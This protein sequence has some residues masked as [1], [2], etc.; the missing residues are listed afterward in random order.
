MKIQMRYDLALIGG[1]VMQVLQINASWPWAGSTLRASVGHQAREWL[2]EVPSSLVALVV[3]N[4][5]T[6][7][8]QETWV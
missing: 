7:Q 2:K 5:P 1:F 3:K 8:M 6:M 4:L